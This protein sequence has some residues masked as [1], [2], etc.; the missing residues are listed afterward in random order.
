MTRSMRASSYASAA[1]VL[2]A[3]KLALATI[4]FRRSLRVL[5]NLTAGV[6]SA[7]ANSDARDERPVDET[8]RHIAT[9]AAFFPG[10]AL[11]LEQSLALY[12]CLRRAGVAA[13]LR[14]G[15]RHTPFTAHAWVELEGRPLHEQRDHLNQLVPLEGSFL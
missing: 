2:I 7:P 12:Y 4:G 13:E 11:C 8:V 14:L 5:G 10:R 9:A 3:V 6:P 15:V 1:F